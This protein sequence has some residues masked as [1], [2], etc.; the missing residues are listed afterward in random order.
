MASLARNT[1]VLTVAKMLN[2]SIYAIFGLLLPGFVSVETNGVYTQISNLM[3]FGSMASSFGIPLVIV[4]SV[5]RDRSR[6]GELFVDARTAMGWGAAV[7]GVVMLAVVFLEAWV[8]G[9]FDP[10]R[11]YLVLMAAGILISD[12]LGSV[13]ESIYQAHEE[14]QFP[15]TMESLTGLLRAGG[16]LLALYLLTP[17]ERPDLPPSEFGRSALYGVFGVFLFGSV[18]RGMILP[19]YARRRYFRDTHLPPASLQRA[20]RLLFESLGIA[21]FRMLRTVRNRIDVLLMGFLLSPVGDLGLQDTVDK[22]RGFYIQAFRVVM[23]FHTV[24]MAFNTALFPRISRLSKDGDREQLRRQFFRALRYQ[25]WWAAP[26]AAVTFFYAADIAGWFPGEYRDGYPGLGSTTD[27]LQILVF[28]LLLDSIGGPVGF[29]LISQPGM[30]RLLPKLGAILAGVSIVLNVI[31][32]PRFGIIGAAYASLGA[33]LIEFLLKPILVSR[34][35][36]NPWPLI[37]SIVPYILLAAAS[38]A[39]LKWTPLRDHAILGGMAVAVIYGLVTILFGLA[40]PAIRQRFN[41]LLPA[42][43]RRS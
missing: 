37:P 19:H 28:A 12:S 14:M 42:A 10:M 38:L 22:G 9:S 40:D 18:L 33:S 24:T 6:A 25:A 36:G 27:V 34:Y 30:D 20:I 7:A 26:L 17:G 8:Q 3:F 11:A 2:V 32:I 23:V 39:L 1:A 13:A 4:R 35:L 5:S 15:A 16:G 29:V 21:L 41:R 31:L 43:L